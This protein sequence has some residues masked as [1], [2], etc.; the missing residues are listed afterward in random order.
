ME[1]EASSGA[2][3]AAEGKPVRRHMAQYAE[4]YADSGKDVYGLFIAVTID[5]GALNN[6]TF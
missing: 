5:T 3:E 1:A 4:Q 2:Q 6:L